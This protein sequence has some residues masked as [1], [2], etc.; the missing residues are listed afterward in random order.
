LALAVLD[1]PNI[2]VAP[3]SVL[4]SVRGVGERRA[5][6]ILQAR[7]EQY[8]ED[9]DDAHRRTNIPMNILSSFSFLKDK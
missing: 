2:N 7:G 4:E 1:T 8:F 6:T 3:R 5:A 9:L